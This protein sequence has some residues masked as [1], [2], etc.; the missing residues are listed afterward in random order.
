[1]VAF[2][3]LGTWALGRKGMVLLL[4]I[5]L[6]WDDVVIDD[7]VIEM[8]W[9]WCWEW[10]WDKMILMLRMTL[11]WDDVVVVVVGCSW[12]LFDVGNRFRHTDEVGSRFVHT[13]QGDPYE[14]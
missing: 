14:V 10:H 7:Y 11:R 6:I 4:M 1:M 5:I 12:S 13:D 2:F 3:I 8:R 9:C